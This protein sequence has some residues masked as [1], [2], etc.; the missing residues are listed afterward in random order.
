[1]NKK[2]LLILNGPIISNGTTGALEKHLPKDA[3]NTVIFNTVENIKIYSKV[4]QFEK[5]MIA[6]AL[7]DYDFSSEIAHDLHAID[8]LKVIKINHCLGIP[9]EYLQFYSLY[10]AIKELYLSG[11][12]DQSYTIV[13][14][15]SDLL[16]NLELLIK[17]CSLNFK[18]IQTAHL[19][20]DGRF[21]D[22]YF[23][24]DY[25]TLVFFL[26]NI[27]NSGCMSHKNIHY[28]AVLKQI[29]IVRILS[30][31]KILIPTFIAKILCKT[32]SHFKLISY[33]EKLYRTCKW[34]GVSLNHWFFSRHHKFSEYFIRNTK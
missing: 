4:A 12:I 25:K 28:D 26:R 19:V 6:C 34:R 9:R 21:Q 1:M 11:D 7:W 22:F 29:A 23:S 27:I 33:S 13:R 30:Y 20:D 15:R 32:V 2:I 16:L 10:N 17:E 31:F 14:I 3:R 5:I 24:A 8:N 18:K